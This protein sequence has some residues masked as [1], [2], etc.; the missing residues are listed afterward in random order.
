VRVVNEAVVR[1][2]DLSDDEM[3]AVEAEQRVELARP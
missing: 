1:Q 2:A 3:A